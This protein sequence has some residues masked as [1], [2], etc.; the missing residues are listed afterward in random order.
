MPSVIDVCN[1]S[2]AQIGSQSTISSITPSDGSTEANVLALLYQ[3][4]IDALFTAAW[5]NFCRK[6]ATLTL[7][8]QAF[9]PSTGQ[10]STDP[11]PLPFLFEYAYPEDCL[12]ARF[13]PRYFVGPAITPPLTTGNNIQFWPPQMSEIPAKFVVGSGL[14]QQGN[15]IKVILTNEPL[16]KLVYS[17]RIEDP[18]LWDSSFYD[19]AVA[20]LAA[21]LVNPLNM[22]RS[23]L[24]ANIAIANRIIGD[25]RVTDGN[26][27][28]H[29]QDH[30][31]DWMAIRSEGGPWGGNWAAPGYNTW[32]S[33]A[34]PSGTSY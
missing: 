1:S 12:T 33:M 29:A 13:I 10:V 19:A 32:S 7:L 16:A 8:R 22:N 31:P 6:Q 30:L 24:Q 2:L 17:V 5:W 25:A 15:Q 26:E 9:N 3:P 20:T 28:W 18:N 23:L 27:G 4:K 21:W 34:W 11:P 14:D